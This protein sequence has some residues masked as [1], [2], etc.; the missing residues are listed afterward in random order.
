MKSLFKLVVITAPVLALV[1]FYIV[2]LQHDQ[3]LEMQRDEAIF[4]Q[5]WLR[6]DDK[7]AGSNEERREIRERLTKAKQHE[8]TAEA[9]MQQAK[10]DDAE[11]RKAMKEALEEED[12]KNAK[13][14]KECLECHKGGVKS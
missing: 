3:K 9:E 5:E 8:A 11:F 14:N 4:D 2:S 12:A 6:F 1:F 13:P 10:K 7:F